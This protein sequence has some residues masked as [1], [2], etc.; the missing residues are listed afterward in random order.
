ML[1]PKVPSQFPKPTGMLGRPLTPFYPDNPRSAE[2]LADKVARNK[3]PILDLF[4]EVRTFHFGATSLYI[5][6]GYTA[7]PAGF[8]AWYGIGRIELL[9]S[10]GQ[11]GALAA[12]RVSALPTYP[13]DATDLQWGNKYG[14]GAA[15]VVGTALPFDEV[16][17]WTYKGCDIPSITGIVSTGQK[18]Y[19]HVEN[20]PGGSQSNTIPIRSNSFAFF[21]GGLARLPASSTL[22]VAFVL[23]RAQF[24]NAD[25][26]GELVN[27]RFAVTAYV[28][29]T[30][31]VNNFTQIG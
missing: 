29:P 15:I 24:N 21:G 28:L 22:D 31:I 1:G 3:T 6:A 2:T 25:A 16:N 19:W 4:P 8:H 20:F 27:V 10:I 9:D 11:E 18:A 26:G 14:E 17:A 12:V 5:P 23:N 30:K 13:D 7:C